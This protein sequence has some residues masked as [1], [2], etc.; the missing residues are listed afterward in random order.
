MCCTIQQGEQRVKL[1]NT[2][3]CCIILLC[4]QYTLRLVN[5][6]NRICLSQYINRS[7]ATKLITFGKYDTCS[8]VTAAPFLILVLV[9]GTVECLCVDNHHVQ[10]AITC[11]TIYFGKLFGVIDKELDTLTVFCGKVFLHGFKTLGYAFAN[12]N[13]GYHDNELIPAIKLIQFIHGFD[14]CISLTGTGLHF[15][16]E[17]RI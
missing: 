1:C 6:H 11:K 12:G 16:G 7:A 4:S 17:H 10:S 8:S 2:F 15:N 13:A 5:N 9:H 14:V 3:S